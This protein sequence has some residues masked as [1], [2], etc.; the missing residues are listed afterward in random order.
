MIAKVINSLQTSPASR[1]SGNK[2]ASDSLTH[3]LPGKFYHF[4][5][6]SIKFCNYYH[7]IQTFASIYNL[8]VKEFGSQMRAY[9]LCG[10]IKIQTLC[11][12]HQWFS[13][14]YA[15]WYCKQTNF[16]TFT[17]LTWKYIFFELFTD[18][19]FLCQAVSIW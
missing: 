10:L 8:S 13:K 9:I 2:S 4:I 14:I 11:K 15:S 3:C 5:F 12:D 18:Y 7:F 6:F 17:Q 1:Q 16:H 19:F